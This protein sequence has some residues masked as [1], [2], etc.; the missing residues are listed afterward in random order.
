MK[1]GIMADRFVV[2]MVSDRSV[3][4]AEEAGEVGITAEVAGA[5]VVAVI[6]VYA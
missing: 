3:G 1:S 4:K 5:E 2:V 6:D